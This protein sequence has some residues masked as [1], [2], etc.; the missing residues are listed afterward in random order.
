MHKRSKHIYNQKETD[1]ISVTHNEKKGRRE[2][3]THRTYWRQEKNG[4]QKK[5]HR[6]IATG[7]K[8]LTVT[9]TCRYPGSPTAWKDMACERKK[10][11]F[12]KMKEKKLQ[13]WKKMFKNIL[14][15]FIKSRRTFKQNFI[16]N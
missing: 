14:K 6:E 2:C 4:G 7:Q 16:S 5:G 15:H 8:I 3:K 12:S 1:E 13:P 10:K 9:K 11:Q